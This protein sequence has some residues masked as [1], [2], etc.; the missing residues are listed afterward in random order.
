VHMCIGVSLWTMWLPNWN[1]CPSTP[2]HFLTYSV[3]AFRIICFDFYL[4]C[5]ERKGHF[6]CAFDCYWLQEALKILHGIV[7]HVQV[8]LEF[9]PGLL[10]CL[11][12]K[13]CIVRAKCQWHGALILDI[14]LKIL[15]YFTGATKCYLSTLK[16]T[17]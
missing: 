12:G 1:F 6:T 7:L 13:H 16:W 10:H 17:V 3:D 11:L 4:K 14:I 8:L 5:E 15:N 9:E 2:K